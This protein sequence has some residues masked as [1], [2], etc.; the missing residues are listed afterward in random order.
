MA[1]RQAD[2][3]SL[4]QFTLRVVVFR[5]YYSV[6]SNYNFDTYQFGY[7]HE[8]VSL[9]AY[10]APKAHAPLAQNLSVPQLT[11]P[12]SFWRSAGP[13][14]GRL[15]GGNTMNKL[16]FIMIFLVSIG[17]AQVPFMNI[18]SMTKSVND[19]LVDLFPLAIGNQWTYGYY[20][21]V[22]TDSPTGEG[23]LEILEP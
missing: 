3:M 23:S 19:S 6:I 13:L 5:F 21:S 9:V 14:G 18:Q 7:Q 12:P 10:C 1:G 4:V 20:W 22:Y 8:L 16:F 2:G 15:R 11:C 17:T